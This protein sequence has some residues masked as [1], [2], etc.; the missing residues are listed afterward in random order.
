MLWCRLLSSADY[1]I[2]FHY[3]Q[4]VAASCGGLT[5]C[6]VAC[7]V[8]SK[9]FLL[10]NFGLMLMIGW[11]LLFSQQGR[12]LPPTAPPQGQPVRKQSSGESI[13]ILSFVMVQIP[14]RVCWKVF[15]LYDDCHLAAVLSQRQ[16]S[17]IGGKNFYLK[18]KIFILL[19]I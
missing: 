6:P 8:T 11:F 10:V 4:L 16:G 9:Q 15:P 17:H 14:D 2:A 12:T 5:T 19:C 1:R 13:V 18:K 3:R 7:P